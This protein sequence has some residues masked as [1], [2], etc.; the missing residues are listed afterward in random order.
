MTLADPVCR[1]WGPLSLSLLGVYFNAGCTVAV[2]CLYREIFSVL[3][4]AS[5]RAAG[6]ESD[7]SWVWPAG[8]SVQAESRGLGHGCSVGMT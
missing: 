2:A 5:Y 1:M 8:L 7:S 6:V 3:L 4:H